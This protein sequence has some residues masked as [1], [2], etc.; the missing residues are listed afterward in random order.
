MK[1]V[2]DRSKAGIPIQQ[3]L[4]MNGSRVPLDAEDMETLRK[5]GKR[6]VWN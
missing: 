4:A 5:Y 6:V 1:F 2:Q 3:L